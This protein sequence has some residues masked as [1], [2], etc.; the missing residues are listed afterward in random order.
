MHTPSF[1]GGGG[2]QKKL[3]DGVRLQ[4]STSRP[5]KWRPADGQ[6]LPSFGKLVENV[7]SGYAHPIRRGIRRSLNS[8]FHNFVH[9]QVLSP[10]SDPWMKSQRDQSPQSAS[11]G[12]RNEAI[13]SRHRIQ[14]SLPP[15]AS[16]PL[17]IPPSPFLS[18]NNPLPGA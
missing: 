5:G 9:M 13:G 4:C 15:P 2:R 3:E 18:L 11:G 7:S 17:G 8:A 6:P 10:N 12:T 1:R 14:Q 16:L